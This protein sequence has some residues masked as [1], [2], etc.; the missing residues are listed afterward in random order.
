QQLL[1]ARA[2][3]AA[4]TSQIALALSEWAAQGDW[5]LYFLAR[6]RIEQVTPASVQTVAARYLQRNN[7]TVGVCIPTDKPERVAIPSTPNVQA[8]LAHYQGRTTIAEGQEFDTSPT[9][10]EA[11]VQ[12]L[13]LPEGMKVTLLPKPSRGADVHLTLTLHYGDAENLK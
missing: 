5:R 10:I 9:N 2:L 13:V 8:L 11:H 7:R 3:A 6:D 4:D 12:R 1:K